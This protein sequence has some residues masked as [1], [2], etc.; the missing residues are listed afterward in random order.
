M[1][2]DI[3]WPFAIK[4][5][6]ERLNS[7]QIDTRG[8]TP[9]SILHKVTV[10]DL[11]VKSYHTLFCPIYVLDA[12]LHSAGGPGPPKWEPRLRIG[13]YLGH[14]SFHAGSVAL[15]W[16]PTTGHVSPQYH[17]IFDDDF[18]TMPYMVA[19]TIPPK[20]TDIVKKLSKMVT[21]IL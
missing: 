15:V 2:D 9:E 6:T 11:P 13:V 17:V 4:A 16:N 10:E 1:V 14:S 7:L 3:F 8:M 18:T 20:W 19:G 5:V 12:R 21:V